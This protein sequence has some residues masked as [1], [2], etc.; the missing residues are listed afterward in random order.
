MSSFEVAHLVPP[1]C[2]PVGE[3]RVLLGEG[4]RSDRV[5]EVGGVERLDI[6]IDCF[7]L[8]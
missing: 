2:G 8:N 4:E 1:D 3:V 7:H 6:R 5:S